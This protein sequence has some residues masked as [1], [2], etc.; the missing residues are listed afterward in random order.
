LLK[1]NGSL[2][3]VVTGSAP[4]T[5]QGTTSYVTHTTPINVTIQ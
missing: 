5:V 2:N 1:T 3:V 4:V